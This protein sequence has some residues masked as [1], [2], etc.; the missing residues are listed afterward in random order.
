VACM[1]HAPKVLGAA[2]VATRVLLM[3]SLV[4]VVR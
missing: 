3:H 1:W 4:P 2:Q